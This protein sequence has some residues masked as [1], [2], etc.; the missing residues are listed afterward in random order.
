M[1]LVHGAIDSIVSPA[2]TGQPIQDV[3]LKAPVLLPYS[4]GNL[5]PTWTPFTQARPD[6]VAAKRI[7]PIT[8]SCTAWGHI[9][10]IEA[11]GGE[12]RNIGVFMRNARD[13]WKT[14]ERF[15]PQWLYG[16]TSEMPDILAMAHGLGYVQGKDF[17]VFSSHPTGREH[18]CGPKTCGVPWQADATQWLFTPGWDVSI[19]QDYMLQRPVE[20]AHDPYALFPAEVGDPK[21]P[22]K[23]NERLTV[24]QCDGALKGWYERGLYHDY[25]KGAIRLEIRMYRDR[26][27]FYAKRAT[28]ARG[29]AYHNLGTRWQALNN[30]LKKIDA[31]P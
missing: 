4:G 12:I 17:Y 25:L 28:P 6:L 14:H 8:L 2:T 22:N 15:G 29:W 16:F 19:L 23:G 24:E 7:V 18:I 21:M 27:Y 13:T 20:H 30:R 3:V 10:D 31:I 9:Y 26:C 1:T 5:W 11:G